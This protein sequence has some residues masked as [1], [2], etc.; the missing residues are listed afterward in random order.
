MCCNHGVEVSYLVLSPRLCLGTGVCVSVCCTQWLCL[1]WIQHVPVGP[2]IHVSFAAFVSLPGREERRGRGCGYTQHTL[3][4]WSCLSG[5]F[6]VHTSGPLVFF[7]RCSLNLTL[8]FFLLLVFIQGFS[9]HCPS[10]TCR[11]LVTSEGVIP[12]RGNAEE[13]PWP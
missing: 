10:S 13:T 6:N 4:L 1:R 8:C 12:C 5:D 7:Q 9:V 3:V 11:V 2:R